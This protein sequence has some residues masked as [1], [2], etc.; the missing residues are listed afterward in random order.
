MFW[1]DLPGGASSVVLGAA[2]VALLMIELH[3]FNLIMDKK[4]FEKFT[5]IDWPGGS[6]S[7]IFI[8]PYQDH[9]ALLTSSSASSTAIQNDVLLGNS[10]ENRRPSNIVVIIKITASGLLT[11]LCQY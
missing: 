11:C 2:D 6:L 9:L 8:F 5:D 1:D 3:G 10:I 4:A 7:R